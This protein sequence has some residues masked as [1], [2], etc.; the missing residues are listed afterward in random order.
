MVKKPSLR[1]ITAIFKKYNLE[2]DIEKSIIYEIKN[3][4]IF[5]NFEV[6]RSLR[7]ASSIKNG[8]GHYLKIDVKQLQIAGSKEWKRR[9]VNT[10]MI[11]GVIESV[12]QINH[13]L[14]IIFTFLY[15]S[16]CRVKSFFSV[17][18]GIEYS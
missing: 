9:N 8:Y 15:Y 6:N 13:V 5:T 17:N 18:I 1:D 14:V 3:A 10:V 2:K 12:S 11:D 4:K 7:E 16:R